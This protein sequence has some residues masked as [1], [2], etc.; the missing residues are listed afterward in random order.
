MGRVF[1]PD[2]GTL[3]IQPSRVTTKMLDVT[4]DGRAA[5]G[6]QP[7]GQVTI[8]AK[9]LDKEIAALQ[10]QAATDPGVVGVLSPLVLAKNLAKP[11]PD[12]SLAWVIAFG[13]GPVTVNGAPLQ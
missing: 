11:N 10:A 9:G 1:L 12:G 13:A 8:T 7:G 2:G 4:L 6:P 5:M 3:T